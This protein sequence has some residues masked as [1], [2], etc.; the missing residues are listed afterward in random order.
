MKLVICD[1]RK[2]EVFD[3]GAAVYRLSA[4]ATPIRL[5]GHFL[6]EDDEAR[7][8]VRDLA[9]AQQRRGDRE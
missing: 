7:D 5:H 6:L 9:K 3:V 8:L 2:L 4:G 1:G